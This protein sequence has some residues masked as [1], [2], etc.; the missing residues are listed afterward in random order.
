MPVTKEQIEQVVSE[1]GLSETSQKALVEELL[2]DQNKAAQFIGQRLRH[3]DYTQKTQQLSNEKKQLETQAREAIQ[4]YANQLA[5]AQTKIDEIVNSYEQEKISAATANARLQSVKTKYNLTDEDVPSVTNSNG[6]TPA[7]NATPQGGSIDLDR[8]LEEFENKLINR[9]LPELA[10]LP[11]INAIQNDIYAQH[12]TLTGKDLTR[13]EMFELMEISKESG[14]KGQ[15]LSIESAWEQKYN[16]PKIRV[17]QQ[18][19]A[20]VKKRLDEAEAKRKQEESERALTGARQTI[21]GGQQQ[22]QSILSPVLKR[23]FQQNP[24]PANG[25]GQADKSTPAPGPKQTGA[26]RA[27]LKYLSR[28][29]QG[30]PLGAPESATAK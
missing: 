14:K 2:A 27:A 28:R 12:R 16:I 10:A 24:D 26:E 13:Q 11:R 5:L 15:P 23:Q 3:S 1:I 29:Q 6:V 17:D 25:S 19:E 4:Q 9:L 22:S 30:I 18:V 21:N 8:R 20:E 7:A